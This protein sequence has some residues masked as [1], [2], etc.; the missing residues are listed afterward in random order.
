MSSAAVTIHPTAIVDSRA[1]LGENVSIG[2]YSIIDGNVLI[3]EGTM[4]GAHCV[5]TGHTTMGKRNRVFAGAIIGSEPQDVKYQ[6]ETCYLEIGD[7]NYIRFS[8]AAAEE[9]LVKALERMK[10]S[11]ALLK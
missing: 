2:P 11:L 3:G 10:E 5:V 8:Y 7:D 6:G 4:I 9:L 1:K